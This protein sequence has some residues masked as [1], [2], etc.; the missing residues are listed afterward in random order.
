MLAVRL[1]N[2]AEAFSSSSRLPVAAHDDGDRREGV[3]RSGPNADVRKAYRL[4]NRLT[5]RSED[6]ACHVPASLDT[7][8]C[9]PLPQLEGASLLPPDFM[10]MTILWV[11]V[12]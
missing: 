8:D 2:Y 7:R 12:I 6:R 5:V 3:I 1:I 10:F 11:T 9:C 4:A